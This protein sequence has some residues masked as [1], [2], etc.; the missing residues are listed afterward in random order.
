MPVLKRRVIAW[1][2][3]QRCSTYILTGQSQTVA[4]SGLA[5][6][7]LVGYMADVMCHAHKLPLSIAYTLICV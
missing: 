2:M 3:R 1:S 7:K 5:C 6:M 4:S